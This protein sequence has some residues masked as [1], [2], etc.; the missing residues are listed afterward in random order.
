MKKLIFTFCLFFIGMSVFANSERNY[1][2]KDNSIQSVKSVL[3]PDQAWVPYPDYTE[4]DKWDEI[5]GKNKQLFI[6][7]G[8]K[9]LDYIWQVVPATAYLEYERSGNRN[10]MQDPNSENNNALADLVMAELAEGAGRFIDQ[11]ING[12]FLQC[13]R[14]SWVLSAHLTAQ[15]SGRTLPD[16]TEQV[17]DLGSAESGA[18]LAWTYYFFHKEFDKVNPVISQRLYSEIYNKIIIPYRNED[19]FWWMG[20]KPRP[21]GLVNNWNPWCNFNVLQCL[22]LLENNPELLSTDV[23]K[24]MLLVDKFINFVHADGACEEGPSYWG[25]AAGKLYDYLQLLYWATDG[26]ISL[27]DNVMIKN[28]GEYISRTYV[29]NNWVVNFADA[30]ARFSSNAGLVYRYGRVINST[31]MM[32]FA[33]YLVSQGNPSLSYGIDIFRSMASVYYYNE[34]KN[35]KAVHNTPE[36]TLYP[37][38]QFYYFKNKNRFFVAAKGGHNEESHNHNDIGTFSLYF[39]ET[40]VIIDAGVGTYVRQTFGPERYTIWTM[41]SVYHNL[42]LINGVEQAHGKEYTSSNIKVNAKSKSFSVD[43][44]SAYPSG[45][46]I[47]KWVRSY[48]LKDK[49]F[50]IEDDFVLDKP[51]TANEVNFLLWKNIDINTPGIVKIQVDNNNME[52]L[53]DKNLFSPEIETIPLPDTRLSKVWGD[54]IYLLKLKAKNISNRGK[55][56]FVVK[57]ASPSP[58]KGGDVKP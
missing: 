22:M 16:H 7:R 14:T 47:K 33:S 28:M 30:S 1:L 50:I 24:T 54:E 4:R 35:T 20:F 23:Y 21:D 40:P 41:R 2:S 10:V 31:E 36:Y 9:K 12:V 56:R 48:Q 38:T 19:R 42:P 57:K 5:F 11:I 18:F 37:E 25:H 45:A 13:E 27:F 55:Y 17:I 52:L 49:E 32:Q 8:E 44:I 29:G 6:S 46:Q 43:L 3:I 15:Y 58:S 51:Q 39:E 34:L 26:N 53:Y